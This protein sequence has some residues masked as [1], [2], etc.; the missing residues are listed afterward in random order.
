MNDVTL[1]RGG[2]VLF[3]LAGAINVVADFLPGTDFWNLAGVTCGIL[4]LPAFY[5]A[6][7]KNAGLPGLLAAVLSGLGLVGITG[8]LFS[9]AF[10]FPS[11]DPATVQTLIDGSTGAAIFVSVILYVLSVLALAASGWRAGVH[12][13]TPLV[14]WGLATLPAPAAMALPPMVMTLAEAVG[15]LAVAWIAV[16]L[17]RR[18]SMYAEKTR[19]GIDAPSQ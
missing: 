12:P 10:I 6:H 15:G 14:L 11:L 16:A 13:K 2:A 8:F 4:G 9:Q 7:R 18:A 3:G 19:W 5:L 1:Y 17:W